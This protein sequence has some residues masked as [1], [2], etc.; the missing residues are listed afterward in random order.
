MFIKILQGAAIGI[1]F[2]LPGL[3]GGTV[4]LLLGFYREFLQDLSRFNL[5][6]YIPHI[7]GGAAAAYAGVQLIGYLMGHA[8]DLL[9]AFILGMLVASIRVV[10]AHEGKLQIRPLPLLLGA[11][12]FMITWF[13]F[14]E[15][16]TGLTV[17]PP[18]SKFHFF[19]GGATASATMLL[20][21]VSG[22]SVLVILNLYDDVIMAVNQLQWFNLACF[23][24]GVAVGL[25]GLARILLALYRRYSA[26]VT[27]VLIGL[28]LGSTRALLPSRID[29][30][31][32][33][34][35]ITGALLVTF[36][37]VQPGRKQLKNP[38]VK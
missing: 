10:M 21:G 6:P 20:P 2:I 35:V 1:A 16:S 13:V 37:S 26:A 3:S 8:N 22:S 12:G 27:F 15:P 36:L 14:C 32:L 28:I 9:K 31:V 25:L 34:A 30:S 4:I 38:P 33:A 24:G 29:P 5:R 7:L 23:A 18:G 17:L 19:L 11:A